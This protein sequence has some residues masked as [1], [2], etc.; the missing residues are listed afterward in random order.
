MSL[1]FDEGAH[2]LHQRFG[3]RRPRRADI[4]PRCRDGCGG[5]TITTAAQFGYDRHGFEGYLG[6]IGLIMGGNGGQSDPYRYT[7]IEALTNE[8][9]PL[10]ARQTLVEMNADAERFLSRFNPTFV[11]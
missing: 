2:L 7:T 10:K 9:D 8:P 1:G 11:G 5:K 4:E 6:N 3:T